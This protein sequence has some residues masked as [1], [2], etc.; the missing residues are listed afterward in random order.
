[1][2]GIEKHRLVAADGTIVYSDAPHVRGTW[3][4]PGQR[5]ELATALGGSIGASEHSSLSTQENADL[6]ERYGEAFEVYVPVRLGGRVAGAYEVYVESGEMRVT[7]M[8]VWLI[9]A[10]SVGVLFQVLGRWAVARQAPRPGAQG[11]RR[12][13]RP[14][15]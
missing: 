5:R 7:L 3:M 12:S 14:R 15:P 6:R 2:L 9:L 13:R 1:M 11:P 10:A 8:A 4:P